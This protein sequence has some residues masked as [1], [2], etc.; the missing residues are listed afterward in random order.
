MIASSHM[1]LPKQKHK[2]LISMP[3]AEFEHEIPPM[4]QPQTFSLD[5]TATGIGFI[6]ITFINFVTPDD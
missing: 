1:L 3:S 4:E 5:G 2:R 6:L